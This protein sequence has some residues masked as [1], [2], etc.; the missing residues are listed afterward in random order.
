MGTPPGIPG[1]PRPTGGPP[2]DSTGPELAVTP[3]RVGGVPGSWVLPV[4]GMI[5]GATP[6]AGAS[7]GVVPALGVPGA[8]LLIEG[9]GGPPPE[10]WVGLC[11][12]E[13]VCAAQGIPMRLSPPSAPTA[14]AIASRRFMRPLD[15]HESKAVVKFQRWDSLDV[16]SRRGFTSLRFSAT[17]SPCITGLEGRVT[18]RRTV[19]ALGRRGIRRP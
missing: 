19:V 18:C 15:D 2:S 16:R 4:P 12:L 17:V 13:D 14:I 7:P 9:G 10:F 3:D 11:A 1:N 8:P 5:P 6:G